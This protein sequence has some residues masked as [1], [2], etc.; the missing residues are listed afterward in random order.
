MRCLFEEKK[1]EF[2]LELGNVENVC[3][4]SNRIR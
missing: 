1:I 3:S 2:K 4:D